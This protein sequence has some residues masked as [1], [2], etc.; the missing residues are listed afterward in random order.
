[1]GAL[2]PRA[3]PLPLSIVSHSLSPRV[4]LPNRLVTGVKKEVIGDCTLYLGGLS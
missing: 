4:C 3:L 1:M 2:H